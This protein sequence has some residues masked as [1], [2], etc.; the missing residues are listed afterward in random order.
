[1]MNA[2]FRLL[3]L[4]YPASFRAEYGSEL[5]ADFAARRCSEGAIALC[6]ETIADTL[7]NAAAAHLDILRQDVRWSVRSLSRTPGFTLTAIAVAAL[8]IGAT[9]GV[10]TLADHVLIRPLP[11]REPERLAKVWENTPNYSRL[12]PSPAN[13]RD[14]VA[15]DA[16]FEDLAAWRQMQVNISGQ[17]EPRMV[18]GA[19]M[20]ADMLPMLG[21]QPLI[22]RLF[23]ADDDRQDT[24]L[25][26]LISY[27]EWRDYYGSD[28]GILG[29]K[30]LMDGKPAEII[31]VM[32]PWFRYPTQRVNIWTPMRF[33]PNDFAD[34]TN[35]Y[36]LVVGRLK[37]GV[38][39]AQAQARM[40]AVAGQ[41]ERQY[42]V[43]NAK[44]GVRVFLLKDEIPP[45]SRM[46]LYALAGAAAG[47]LL[48][49][50]TNLANLL[51]ARAVTR[52][53]ELAIRTS[54]GAG[55]ER[56]ARQ[57]MT[58][59]LLLC[60]IAGGAG[61]ALGVVILPLLA[62]LVPTMLPLPATPAPDLRVWLICGGLTLATGFG[63]GLLP[64][65]LASRDTGTGLR[66]GGRSSTPGA[67]RDR[68]R[69]ALVIGEVTACT[70]LL[71]GT[72][73]LLRALWKLHGTD[74][75][76]AVENRL[77]LRTALPM[78]KYE[79]V[80]RRDGFY[81]QVLSQTTALPGV[82]AAG[83]T[84]FTPVA[85][86]GGIWEVNLPGDVH[87]RS[88][89]RFASLR[90]VTPDYFRAMGIPLIAGRGTGPQD[91]QKS[92]Y[93]AVVSQSFV[94]QYLG[95]KGSALGQTFEFAFFKRTIVGVAGNIRTRGYERS[96]EPQ[97]YL[98]YRQIPD[99]WM[100]FYAPKDLVV[101]AADLPGTLAAIRRIVASA[102]PDQPVSTV[103][104]M[105]EVVA[106]DTEGRTTQLYVLGAFAAAALLLAAVGIHGLLAFGVSE[107]RKE[108]GVRL[109]L[110][111]LPSSI[112]RLVLSEG[113]LLGALG[114]A[115]GL[116]AAA[117]VGR[118]LQSLLAGVSPFDP[119]AF[120]TA[121]ALCGAMA[122][123]GSLGPALRAIRVDPSE[124]IRAE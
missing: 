118:T 60:L 12:E 92:L 6:A 98:P 117:W 34:R 28:P 79:S 36:L 88:L 99:G 110:G 95:G 74:L 47:L 82:V 11:Y 3:L 37:R 40:N 87:D 96:S 123:L 50:C 58:E 107:R 108:I 41:L 65:L 94:D 101:H 4:L 69:A 63:F 80:A 35:T 48:I 30:L 19:A 113:A 14:W 22:G 66:D 93:V 45:Q 116:T 124:A 64:A 33:A 72:G 46:L 68:I 26:A 111:A 70:V 16:P 106:T 38:S 114:L 89:E 10:F 29:R 54:L 44:V 122:L 31:G 112:L 75:G 1:M 76:F 59:S 73:L 67:R 121:A 90:Y 109:A 5:A 27:R 77:T 104:T 18:D 24:P 103:R 25:T 119:I 83:Y 32:P 100:P 49:A 23:T 15:M 97:V 86:G 84:S 43:D 62:K 120:G 85:M 71:A 56:L 13:Y 102:D 39:L 91:T 53:R 81:T 7:W 42:P 2:L 57:L 105:E 52:R 55:R 115:C 8:G 78:P 51:L 20:T 21:V 17:G 61:A 9:V